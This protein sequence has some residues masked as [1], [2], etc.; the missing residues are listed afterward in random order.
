MIIGEFVLIEVI[1]LF[2]GGGDEELTVKL[3]LV[4]LLIP[5]PVPVTVMVYVPVGV[6]PDVL[7]V[8]VVEQS[9]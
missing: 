2:E 3:Q 7:I 1:E 4:V 9:G 8:N 5:P 6:E